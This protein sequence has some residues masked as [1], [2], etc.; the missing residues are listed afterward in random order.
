MNGRKTQVPPAFFL[1]HTGKNKLTQIRHLPF[2]YIRYMRILPP[3][4]FLLVF[5]TTE[6]ARSQSAEKAN[7]EEAKVGPLHLPALF[8]TAAEKTKEHWMQQRRPEILQL[9]QQHVYGRM[10]GKP[11]GMW[12]RTNLV[13]DTSFGGIAICK[14]VTIF[15]SPDTAGPGLDVLLYLPKG[16]GKKVPVFIGLNFYG[17]QSIAHDPTIQITGRWVMDSEHGGVVENKAQEASRGMQESRWPVQALIEK[18]YGLATAYYG[19]LEPDHP[20]GWRDGVRGRLA[21]ALQ[22]KPEAWA[23]IGAWGWGLSRMLDYLQTE[24]GVDA[25]KII[26]TGHSRLGK[27]ALW[28]GANDTRFAAVVSNESGEGGAALARRNF[29]ETVERINT[30]FP[31]WFVAAFKGFNKKPEAL[32]V[33]QHML[34]ASMAPRPLYIASAA[35][36]LWAD[37]KGEFLSAVYAAPAYEL[38]GKVALGTSDMPPVNKPV[39]H[40]IRY[41]IRSGAHDITNYDW[42]QY[43]RF[44]NEL[45]K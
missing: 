35:E 5:V 7:Y 41:H 42:E 19:D 39:G 27:A 6:K 32:P 36:D 15:F 1:S 22:T 38:F 40:T 8:A 45:V 20:E 10:P 31:H 28:A 14:Q 4:L 26:V 23:A 21:N 30:V 17:N 25:Q 29:G 24:P 16:D 2:L 43:I 33:D 44:A 13:N 3:L 12:F 37:P 11:T 18:G 9:F 34:L